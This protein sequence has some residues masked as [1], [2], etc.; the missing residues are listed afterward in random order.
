MG[1]L[2]YQ[3]INSFRLRKV[4][5]FEIS[6][7]IA[8]TIL[9]S[10]CSEFLSG[11]PKAQDSIEIQSNL[12][13]CLNDVTTDLQNFFDSKAGGEVLDKTIV[14]VDETLTTLQ[15][16][17]EGREDANAFTADEIYDIFFTF[18]KGATIT[19]EG[20]KNLILLKSALLGGDQTRITK[21]EITDL[22]NYLHIIKDEAK[23]LI[24]YIPVYHFEK[25]DKLY[26]KE[27]IAA[28]FQALNASIKVL[29]KA[30]KLANSDYSFTDFKTFLI[31]VLNLQSEEKNTVEILTKVNY[32]LNGYALD[33]DDAEKD[34]YVD[35]LTEFLRLTSL[36]SN[37]YVGFDF[38]NLNEL[39]NT[40]D[41]LYQGLKLIENSLQFRKTGV[42]SVTSLDHLMLAL[43]ESDK[44]TYKVRASSLINFYKTIFVRIFENGIDGNIRYFTGIKAVNIQ[45]IRR[46]IAVYQIYSRLL[47]K[48]ITPEAIEAG[49]TVYDLRELQRIMGSFDIWAEADILNQFDDN[50]QYIIFRIV[51]EMRNEFLSETPLVYNFKKLGVATNQND[52]KQTQPDLARGLANKMLSRLLMLGWGTQYQAMNQAGNDITEY[53]MYLWYGEF[54]ALL[55]DL[56]AFDPRTAN[57]GSAFFKVANLFT[58]AGNGDTKMSFRELHENLSILLSGGPVFD[59]IYN[60]L[61]KAKCL[62]PELDVFDKNWGME[63]CYEQL[64]DQN[65]RSYYAHLPHLVQYL[66]GLTPEARISYFH[67]ITNIS[68]ISLNTENKQ[69]ESSDIKGTNSIL[70]FIEELYVVNDTN[71]NNKF[72]EAEIR[73]AY[74]KF[75]SVA[76]E[77]AESTAKD[78]LDEF[79]SWKGDAA[80]FGCFSRNDLIRE[81]FIFLTFNGRLPV[82]EDFNTL[83]CVLGNPLLTFRGEVDRTQTSMVFKSLR[84]VLAPQ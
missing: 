13:D 73:A 36:H 33:L 17:V 46:E 53:S 2:G 83:P 52:W 30:S 45:N 40:V 12:S 80:G 74:P 64:L 5:H 34:L 15:T 66:D 41:F 6:I 26:S 48:T 4:F 75:K 72:S 63:S 69:V 57:G 84:D 35:N 61:G 79:T 44:F 27:H 81:S 82:L 9:F 32:V 60:D 11:K 38:E 68:R 22:K 78:Q 42:I 25:T 55:V 39:D 51:E 7:L 62:L 3:L 20:S 56:K 1:E 47:R 23:K 71:R 49:N 31:N 50:N 21:Q 14:C 65:Y 19:R 70:Y 43:S 37:G 29:V 76:T 28:A 54:K 16:K 67:N 18:V 77:F 58:H 24:P 8:T 59:A 10:S